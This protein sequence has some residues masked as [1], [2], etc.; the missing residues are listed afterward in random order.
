MIN[1]NAESGSNFA[2]LPA[3]M[4]FMAVFIFYAFHAH[5]L[6][7]IYD[8]REQI[9]ADSQTLDFAELQKIFG[10]PHFT[11]N[12]YYR[13]LARLLLKLQ[14]SII[15]K[16]P[17]ALHLGNCLLAAVMA[18]LLFMVLKSTIRSDDRHLLALIS[19]GT[20][21]H[22]IT[23]SCV[24][25]ISGQEALL[26]SALMLLSVWF[27]RQ[28]QFF[29]AGFAALAAMLC[30]ENALMLPPVLTVM[31]LLAVAT[32]ETQ[33]TKPTN[34][35]GKGAGN[36]SASKYHLLWRLV[37]VWAAA[38]TYLLIR[39][40]VL[41]NSPMANVSLQ[42]AKPVM[43][44]LY[45]FQTL[46]FPDFELVYEPPESVWL[47]TRTFFA[48]AVTILAIVRIRQHADRAKV[49]P[50]LA[51]IFIMFLPTTNL[52]SQQ[53]AYDERHNL[54]TLPGFAGVLAAVTASLTTKQR[55]GAMILL[56]AGILLLSAINQ[57]RAHF[58][59]NDYQFA[60]QWLKRNPEAGEAWALMGSLLRDQGNREAALKSFEQA[61]I[62]K[63][64]MA[65][66]WDNLGTLL[67]ESGKTSQAEK[68]LR[69]AIALDPR[70]SYY[71]YNL[72]INL[73]GTGKIFEAF[74]Q[75]NLA[76][77]YSVPGLPNTDQIIT[78]AF[79]HLISSRKSLTNPIF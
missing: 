73:T 61:I 78:L 8:D 16:F 30:R 62:L 60:G 21:L 51:W 18:L 38:F 29:P 44:F 35:P 45:L 20:A 66:A 58:F 11:N 34:E 67:G 50:W 3:V 24:Y 56:C 46:L 52:L 47:S 27:F 22:P 37:P 77:M 1:S 5:N 42:P 71:R 25:M 9:L 69:Q 39:S 15:G 12:S 14:L 41:D 53:T 17:G 70:N 68:Y 74:A 2:R 63:P 55:R 65:S 6:G 57:N 28:N 54:T 49:W 13:P 76:S 19:L 43:A 59:A 72:G 7:F 36:H 32:P 48:A 64:G 23:S 31:S 10:S 79:Y 33:E 26:A 75:L 40:Q 4:V